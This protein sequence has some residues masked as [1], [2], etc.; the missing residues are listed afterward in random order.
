[1]SAPGLYSVRLVRSFRFAMSFR[2][3]TLRYHAMLA[4]KKA[5]SVVTMV[6]GR[7]AMSRLRCELVC[8]KVWVILAIID[9]SACRGARP[10]T[11][12]A[13]GD[14]REN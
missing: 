13:R 11:R 8:G 14:N 4:D 9:I 6:K 1:M 3:R 7:I 5:M 12:I 2:N 10:A